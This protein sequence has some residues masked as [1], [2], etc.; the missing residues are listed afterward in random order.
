MCMSL[1]M[2]GQLQDRIFIMNHR[3]TGGGYAVRFL[4]H[5]AQEASLGRE[6]LSRVQE[7]KCPDSTRLLTHYSEAKI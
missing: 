4:L 2:H 6:R 5:G 7:R 1:S 3:Q